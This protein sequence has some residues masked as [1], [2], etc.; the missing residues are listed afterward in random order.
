MARSP[1]SKNQHE[2]AV[3][4]LYRAALHPDEM[5]GAISAVAARVGADTFHFMGWDRQ[6][7]TTR[8]NVYSHAELANGI[9]DYAAY[10]GAIDP[11]RQLLDSQPVGS[12]LACHQHFSS[13][14]VSRDEFFQDF[15]IPAGSRYVAGARVWTDG[16]EDFVL[17]LMR[18]VGNQPF[19]AEALTETERLVAHFG[20][21]SQLWADTRAL[22]AA[23]A[24]G[25][26]V[27]Q[28]QGLAHFGL[29]ALGELV[30]ANENAERHL[31]EASVLR[32]IHS[33][34]VGCDPR[35]DEAISSGVRHA[36]EQRSGCSRLIG[37]RTAA[38]ALMVSIAPLDLDRSLGGW[39]LD[40]ASVLVT[41]R[42]R[43]FGA[44]PSA[45]ALHQM[46]GLSR[47]EG[48]LAVALCRGDTLQEYAEAASL[49][50]ATVR[51]QLKA[52]FQKTATSRQAELVSLLLQ[53]PG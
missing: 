21:A 52:V 51:T 35:D 39:N 36:L 29:N 48:A 50:V 1:Q 40:Q 14:A 17:G 34:V 46:Y 47:A 16:N 2:D 10:Y 45:S 11:R 41:V 28:S 18:D 22:R 49:S 6:R 5:H 24:A 27:A 7:M 26:R 20:R 53:M 37:H 42:R 30:Y 38:G 19:T 12:V 4:G 33:K 9:E 15:L 13:D 3:A 25:E 31:R 43:N 32:L 44:A 8:F 23:A